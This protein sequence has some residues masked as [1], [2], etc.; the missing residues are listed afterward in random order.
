A[1]VL[2]ETTSVNENGELTLPHG[3]TYKV[4]VLPK[5]DTMRPELLAKIKRLVAD[6]AYV[7]GPKPLRSPSLQNQPQADADVKKMADELWGDVDGKSL[8]SRKF[9]K[10]TI[11]WGLTLEEVFAE[12]K[13]A[14]DCEIPAGT[15]L[16]YNR[17]TAVDGDIYFL[18]NQ[19]DKELKNVEIAFRVAG[20]TPEIWF[21]ATGETAG[22]VAREKDGRAIATLNFAPQESVFVVF[23]ENKTQAVEN[24]AI[25]LKEIAALNGSWTVSF[26]SG[27]IA[28]GP[29]APVV[30]DKLID[31]TQSDDAA[32]K[33]YSG[34]A[35]Y[36]TTCELPKVAEG[37]RVYLS[38]GAVSEMAK[39]KINGEYVGGV[40]TAPYRL[41]IT[42]FAREGKNDVEVEVVN[43]WVNRL[44]GDAG[45]P[46]AER[47]TWCPV[48]SYNAKSPLKRSGL[49]GPV[50]VSTT[51]R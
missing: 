17:R 30:F 19:S 10:G 5:L 47:K 42:K 34:N 13:C 18:A 50:T 25:E 45:L 48:N 2:R 1:E 46:E 38:L 39:V 24:K 40:W 29:K 3:T 6:G 20:K 51:A 7:L 8:K 26:D 31:W 14:P 32:I 22:V 41:D 37:E 33:Y 23:R 15:P 44:I 28:R 4:L 21:P 49:I 11:A 43:C 12:L 27:E 9:G 36:K 35:V 16:V